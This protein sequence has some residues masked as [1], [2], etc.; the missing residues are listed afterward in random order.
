MPG[1][2]LGSSGRAVDT[3]LTSEPSLQPRRVF[4]I[5]VNEVTFLDAGGSLQHLN[6][7]DTEKP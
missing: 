4:Q 1:T 2:E 7:E 3:R 6:S 5:Q